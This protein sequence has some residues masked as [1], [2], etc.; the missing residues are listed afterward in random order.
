[1]LRS[2][3]FAS[4]VVA[5]IPTVLPFK[6]PCCDRISSTIWK[7]WSCTSTLSRWRMR[8]SDEWSGVAWSMR[9]PKKLRSASES[10]QRHAIPRSESMP[11]K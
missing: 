7:T 6:S 5:S 2:A 8:D 9:K 3:A 4:S 1:M 11:S 10:A